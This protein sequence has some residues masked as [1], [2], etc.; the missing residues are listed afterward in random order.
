MEMRV[1]IRENLYDFDQYLLSFI[2][3]LAE[4]RCFYK[5]SIIGLAL[6]F[7]RLGSYYKLLEIYL[8]DLSP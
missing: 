6:L 1:N 2:G 8:L 4:G 3:A 7:L 5:R